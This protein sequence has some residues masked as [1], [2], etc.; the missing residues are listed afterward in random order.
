MARLNIEEEV[1]GRLSRLA[2]RIG[3]TERGALGLLGLLWHDSQQDE[4]SS[5][6]TKDE[7]FDLCRL[8]LDPNDFKERVISALLKENFII[9]DKDGTYNIRGNK[10]EI[11]ALEAYKHRTKKATEARLARVSGVVKNELSG[12]VQ[13]ET[14]QDNENINVDENVTS[15]LRDR[16]ENVNVTQCNA[17]QGN[18]IQFNSKQF[19]SNTD[20]IIEK[21]L[22]E[23]YNSKKITQKGH[24]LNDENFEKVGK[25]IKKCKGYSVDD[26]KQAIENYVL[27]LKDEGYLWSH[28]YALWDFISGSSSKRF[29]PNEFDIELCDRV[30]V[31]KTFAQQKQDN[32][33]NM[34]NPYAKRG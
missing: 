22:I 20:Y 6:I 11:A 15:T 30:T 7:L 14:K 19:N 34:E 29:Y 3:E 10:K 25:A 9:L 28:K 21:E 32:L 2:G 17:I 1:F 16:N 26:I 23:F 31:K 4:I 33:I 13:D 27:V 18:A 5:G 8:Y 12:V 24:H